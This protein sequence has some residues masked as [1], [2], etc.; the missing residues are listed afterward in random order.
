MVDPHALGDALRSFPV[1][2]PTPRIHEVNP[3]PT[4]SQRQPECLDA[5]GVSGDMSSD[6][7]LCFSHVSSIHTKL[8]MLST[9]CGSCVCIS[10][11]S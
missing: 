4:A 2:K 6:I 3:S 7:C 8:V 5:A 9:Q 1:P 11:W 10:V